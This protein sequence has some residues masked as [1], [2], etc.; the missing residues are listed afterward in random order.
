MTILIS[1]IAYMAVCFMVRGAG[2]WSPKILPHCA[3]ASAPQYAILTI[4]PIAFVIMASAVISSFVEGDWWWTVESLALALTV[5]L[6]IDALRRALKSKP[7]T[8]QAPQQSRPE[9]GE[10]QENG[11]TEGAS[12]TNAQYIL[13]FA[14]EPELIKMEADFRLSTMMGKTPF[15][16]TRLAASGSLGIIL[17]NYPSASVVP[18]PEELNE[19]L[20]APHVESEKMCREKIAEALASETAKMA[21]ELENKE[22]Q[23]KLKEALEA[24]RKYEKVLQ[25][26]RSRPANTATDYTRMTPTQRQEEERRL[27]ESLSRLQEM[28]KSSS[29]PQV[30]IPAYF[31]QPGSIS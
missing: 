1:G 9:T 29:L 13:V 15:R 28:A 7:L 21:T 30:N 23:G 5:A 3:S 14:P 10:E 27:R 11:E 19:R 6:I 16:E 26:L 25:D 31:K 17:E 24:N 4:L 2:K 12:Q 18:W 20:F 22:L 8:P